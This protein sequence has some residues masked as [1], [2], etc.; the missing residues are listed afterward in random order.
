[1]P[2]GEGSIS[3]LGVMARA[4]PDTPCSSLT[5]FQK[6]DTQHGAAGDLQQLKPALWGQT[7]SPSLS[8]TAQ[9]K[10][11]NYFHPDQRGKE[12]NKEN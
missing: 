4:V 5:A 9:R 7:A 11:S 1:M 8:A 3:R 2:T 6:P 10:A 12:H